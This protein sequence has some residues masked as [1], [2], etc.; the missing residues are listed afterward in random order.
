MHQLRSILEFFYFDMNLGEKFYV[1]NVFTTIFKQ[2]LYGK[3][4]LINKEVILLV[5]PN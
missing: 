2:I 5:D 4:L 3:L 1:H